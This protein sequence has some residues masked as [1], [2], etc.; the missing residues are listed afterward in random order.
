MDFIL[1]GRILGHAIYVELWILDSHPLFEQM[2]FPNLILREWKAFIIKYN[3]RSWG[4]VWGDVVRKW[5][6]H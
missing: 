6:S 2:K 1:F 3:K 4:Q 5:Q